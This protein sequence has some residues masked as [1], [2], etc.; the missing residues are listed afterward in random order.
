MLAP[1]T[2]ACADQLD[3]TFLNG[4]RQRRLYELA[5]AYCTD[6]LSRAPPRSPA[7]AE[8]TVELIRTLAQHAIDAPAQDRERLW[9]SAHAVAA[10]FLR[11]APPHPRA[12][13]VRFQDAL[14]LLARGEIIRQDH[15]AGIARGEQL[16]LGRQT[17]RQAASQLETL[18]RSLTSQLPLRRR[19]APA[20]GELTADE[21][22]RLEESVRVQLT[23]ANKNRALLFDRGSDD[24]TALLLASMTEL[25][26]LLP[27]FP[28]DEPLAVAIR[29]ELAE[30]QRLLGHHHEAAALAAALDVDGGAP[31]ARARAR[32]ELIRVAI[33]RGDLG[34][35]QRLVQP[36]PTLADASSPDLDFARFEALLAQARAAAEGERISPG[37]RALPT[38]QA[39][40][41]QQQAGQAAELLEKTHGPFWGRRASQMLISALPRGAMASA[42]LLARAADGL[43]LQGD[44]EQAI[45][46]YDAAAAQARSQG[47]L[48]AAFELA[49]KAALIEQRRERQLP[50]ANRLR[51]LAK[52]MPTHP[53]AS[54]A[55][56]RAAWSA[57]QA[58]RA[59]PSA[60][61]VYEELLDEHLALWPAAESANQARIW[62]GKVC[63]AK[64]DWRGAIEA[65]ARVSRASPHYAG[66]MGGLATAWREQ[67]AA[68]AAAG[69]PTTDVA[70]EAIPF[71]RAAV[72]GPENHWPDR[73]TGA[74]R[75]AALAAAELIVAYQPGRASDAED[76][77]R[78]AIAGSFDAPPAWQ[79]AA[80]AQLVLALAAQGSRQND[81]LAEL[82]AIGAGSSEEMLAVLDGLSQ[83]AARAGERARPQIA[84]VQLAAIA[85]IADGRG[86]PSVDQQ[87]TLARIRADALASV[88]R[89]DEA[90]AAY[91]QLARDN[92]QTGAVQEG[93]ARLLL[94]SSVPGQLKQALDQ[95]R[96]VASR[97]RPRT[98]RWYEAKYSVALAQY[99][100]GD[101]ESA[102]TLLRYLLET[103]P[104]VQGTEWE[105]SYSDLLKKCE[106]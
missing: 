76:L 67:L 100:L 22:T 74:D 39:R 6:R 45:A 23:R 68:L 5:E 89:R 46:A 72:T 96:I 93:Y 101:R 16:E 103:P 70:T 12:D 82:R 48:Q 32:A 56:L 26:R 53:Q 59:E 49:Y 15:E 30:C 57:A 105:A 78:R 19:A 29:L 18:S 43:Y 40:K 66:A 1:Q 99:K 21:M 55:H 94:S 54:T 31:P 52:S 83:I 36:N 69:Q 35:A 73:W 104:G 81:A 65:Y 92:P 8:L 71:F 85:M 38:E 28:A 25:D 34:E 84:N 37:D 17:L 90:L 58:A 64:Q 50:A 11:S 95:W 41:Y 7:Q 61:S 4:L 75:A 42:E 2:P 13:L 77:L 47:D 9:A 60:Q 63:D 102:A 80:Q 97:T 79:T 88:G 106:R 44:L 10:G 20:A 24:R 91:E 86:R 98:T 27:Q 62:L 3:V 51:I 33:A 87:T 14:T